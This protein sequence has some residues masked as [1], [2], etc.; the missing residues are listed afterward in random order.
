MFCLPKNYADKFRNALVSG[1]IVPEKL[2]KLSSQERREFFEEIVG[3][4]DAREVNAMYES[5]LLLKDQKRGLVTWAKQMAGL[6]E[7]VRRDIIAKIEKMDNILTPENE[8]AFLE[9]LAAKKLGTDVSFE[10]AEVI[11][12]LSKSL[13]ELKKDVSKGEDERLL[14]GDKLVELQNYVNDLKLNAEKRTVKSTVED[15]K[16]APVAAMGELLTDLAGATKSIRSSLDLSVFLRQLLPVLTR[17]PIIWSENLGK[18]ISS[19]VKQLGKKAGDESVMNAFKADVFSRENAMN[20]NYKKMK[21]DIGSGEEAYPVASQEKIPGFGRL[22]AASRVGFEGPAMRVRADVADKHIEI[23]KRQGILDD[24]HLEDAG[25]F[26]NSMTGRGNLGSFEGKPSK[27]L[28]NWVF[29]PKYWKSQLDTFTMPFND[30]MSVYARK[31]AA[32]NTLSTASAVAAVYLIANTLN[33]GSVETDPTS[34]DFGKIRSGNTRF[35]IAGGKLSAV[36]LAMRMFLNSSKSTTSGKSRELNTGKFGASDS[37]DLFWNYVQ[38]KASPA[39]QVIKEIANRRDF[40]GNPTTPGTIAKDL[41]VPL[42]VSDVYELA[43]TEGGANTLIGA[44]A[45]FFGV[46]INT[47]K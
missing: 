5:K 15:F 23:M 46:G 36:V 12:G 26:I 20:G 45:S 47:Y 41:F 30:K 40:D 38:N 33:P 25:L 9:D 21:L 34:S 7:E 43:T 42:P 1:K 39:G 27:T 35:D 37:D 16:K 22:F 24:K 6:K 44:L 10:E 3:K 28:N 18:G 13:Q 32:L 4:E 29:S 14:Y 31:Q 8:K 19:F 11:S 2:S 17:N